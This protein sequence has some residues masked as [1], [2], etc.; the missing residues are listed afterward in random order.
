[1]D[2]S[3]HLPVVEVTD[4]YT[5]EA[6][7]DLTVEWSGSDQDG[8]TLHYEVWY[9]DYQDTVICLGSDIADDYLT[10]D[11]DTLPGTDDD[12]G[13]FLIYVT[14]GINTTYAFSEDF[15]VDW[16]APDFVSPDNYKDTYLST[17]EVCID[18]DA[19]DMQ[20]GWLM[21][22]DQII[23]YNEAGEI[24]DQGAPMLFYPYELTPNQT[25]T[26]TCEAINQAGLSAT[27]EISFF[28]ED[29][30]DALPD[31][32]YKNSVEY[33]L[34]AGYILPFANA[35]SSYVTR[36][37]LSKALFMLEAYYNDDMEVPDYD[38]T[39]VTDLT[40]DLDVYEPFWVVYNGY[41]EAPNGKFDPYTKVTEAEALDAFYEIMATYADLGTDDKME[42]M[43]DLEIIDDIAENDYQPDS[44][45]T[46]AKMFYRFFSAVYV[47]D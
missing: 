10:M 19:Y 46:R 40:L 29:N 39:L 21:D 22:A 13:Y 36:Y 37:D 11:M 38:E 6:G 24:I 27:T 25:H 8:D 33:S 43:T 5:D 1:M 12:G 23:W 30:S 45:L 7:Q 4:F 44:N 15:L 18:L 35:E 3:D 26:I 20:E 2:I 34:S 47:L 9:Q 16:K 17:E 31:T 14:D 41:M 32:W 28:V 42:A